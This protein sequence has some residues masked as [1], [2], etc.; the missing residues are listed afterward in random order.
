MPSVGVNKDYHSN[1]YAMR[2]GLSA[3]PMSG[4][5]SGFDFTLGAVGASS[6]TVTV[7]P[8]TARFD[9]F[10]R[11][12]A[13]SL[14]KAIPGPDGVDLTAIASPED[15][16]KIE[17]YLNPPRKVK[18]YTDP[19][20][21]PAGVDGDYALRALYLT[22]KGY[23]SYYLVEDIMVMK[24]SIWVPL[25]EF[26]SFPAGDGWNALPFN[27]ID[28]TITVDE[29]SGQ[30]E[31]PI[32]LG[33]SLPPHVARAGLPMIRQSA[34]IMLGEITVDDSGATISKTLPEYHMLA[35]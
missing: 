22:A 17:V 29:L 18:T 15:A 28:T 7:A 34:G 24:S 10:L 35:V 5:I 8:G 32:F 21:P 33:S 11:K 13:A 25:D 6:V 14:T 16:V 26:E 30:N 4:V 19:A 1:P 31:V 3:F 23:D 2:G 20:T 27:E 9:G 12:S